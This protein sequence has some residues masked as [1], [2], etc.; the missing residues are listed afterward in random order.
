MREAIKRNWK[1]MLLAAVIILLPMAVGGA[2][3]LLVSPAVAQTAVL[4]YAMPCGLNT[5]VFPRLVNENC[6]TGASLAVVSSLL[7]CLTIPF[8]LYLF[9]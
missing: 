6:E 4:I 2:L 1:G 8:C 3:W 7:C 9:T 5:I